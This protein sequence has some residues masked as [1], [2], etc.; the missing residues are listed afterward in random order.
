VRPA[1]RDRVNA[2]PR[3]RVLGKVPPPRRGSEGGF[4][5]WPASIRASR[6]PPTA[7]RLIHLMCRSSSARF[8]D[9]RYQNTVPLTDEAAIRCKREE[10]LQEGSNSNPLLVIGAGGS[11]GGNVARR[12]AQE[13][14]HA[15]LCRR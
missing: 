3:S 8:D 14:Y 2:V 10:D 9:D 5:R 11:I 12:F 13:G 1:A 4:R 15:C 6:I 7:A